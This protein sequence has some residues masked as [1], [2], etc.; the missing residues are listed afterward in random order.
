MGTENFE[1]IED[2]IS[3]EVQEPTTNTGSLISRRQ[4]LSMLGAGAGALALGA[5][6]P[7]GSAVNAANAETTDVETVVESDV[8]SELLAPTGEMYSASGNTW[9]TI[10]GDTIN[11]V[12]PGMDAGTGELFAA[13]VAKLLTISEQDAGESAFNIQGNL[14]NLG[15]NNVDSAFGYINIGGVVRIGGGDP[16]FYAEDGSTI[17]Q[18]SD[19]GG[20]TICSKAGTSLNI[21]VPSRDGPLP[22]IKNDMNISA[23]TLQLLKFGRYGQAGMA[24]ANAY[25]AG[26]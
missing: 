13:S 22:R 19:L 10:P 17:C 12:A 4:F 5:S 23:A 26:L 21:T 8:Q 2:I 6:V 1:Q 9:M 25:L 7:V 14:I 20:I 24:V 15:I 3:E 18:T 11:A 16:A